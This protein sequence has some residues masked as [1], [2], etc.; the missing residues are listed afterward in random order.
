LAQRLADARTLER[1]LTGYPASASPLP[2]WSVVICTRDRTD[3]LESCLDSLVLQTQAGGEIVVVDNA[4]SDERTAL[5][6]A[7]Y[8]VHYVR[9]ERPGLNWARDRG[10]Q[11]AT[12]EI[13]L[14]SDDDVVMDP[15]WIS[16]M[17]APFAHPRVG[18]VTGLT[19]PLELET[20]AQELFERYGGFGRGFRRR[21][22]DYTMMAPAAAGIVGAGANMAFRRELLLKLRLFQAELDCGTVTRSG[23]DAYAFYLL[24][25]EGYQVVYEPTALV[26]HRHRRD[27]ASLRRTLVGYSIGG[28][29]FLMRCWHQHGDWQ[30]P[31]VAAQWFWTDHVRQLINVLLR[32]PGRL[33]LDLVLAQIAACPLGPWAYFASLKREPAG[34]L[35]PAIRG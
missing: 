25:S 33:P 20:E 5:L 4:P 15:G 34:I 2:T 10:A 32:H 17:L 8:P 1:L 26:W 35:S 6:V 12:G 9:E 31:A 11:A 18:A 24:L 27:Y 7:R 23:G 29:A 22:F 16:A 3:D 30:A 19:M 13:V 28:F 21:A 14:Y